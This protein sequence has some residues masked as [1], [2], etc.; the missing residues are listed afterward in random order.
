MRTANKTIARRPFPWPVVG[1]L[2]LAS[3]S[4]TGCSKPS[5]EATATSSSS[6]AAIASAPPVVA[7]PPGMAEI[8]GGTFAMG[9]S[10]GSANEKPVHDV[11]LS[12]YCLDITEVT[13]GAYAHCTTCAAEKASKT[14]NGLGSGKDDHPQNCVSWH[15]AKAY[16]ESVDKQLPTEAE[17]EFAARGGKKQLKWPWGNT[18][19]KADSA[20][21]NREKP[22]LGTCPVKSSPV[23]AFGLYDMAGNVW[24]WVGDWYD[25]SYPAGAGKDPLGPASG[26]SRAVRGGSW[27]NSTGGKAL[28]GTHRSGRDTEVPGDSQFAGFRCARARLPAGEP[29]ATAITSASASPNASAVAPPAASERP[30]GESACPSGMAKIPGG[31]FAMGSSDGHDNEKPVHDVELSP[32]CIDLT[33]VTVGAYARCPSCRA[34]DAAEGCNAAGKG[35]DNHPQNCVFREDAEAFCASM[36]KQLPTEAQW[37]YAARGGQKQSKWP[38]GDAPPT[39]AS[40]CWDRADPRVFTCPVKAHPASTFGLYDMAG[41]VYEWVADWYQEPY[42]QAAA[43]DPLG[44]SKGWY[45]VARGG[46]WQADVALA[47]RGTRRQRV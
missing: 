23:E 45:Y 7:C 25:A 38:W 18:K 16:C 26:W 29:T 9:S 14:C 30:V 36:G 43:K 28:R 1:S 13:V 35:K 27:A 44:P 24:E 8:P 17:W 19:P 15:D 37:E 32:Y 46:S 39:K 4:A 11:E 40:A 21:W 22:P 12:P 3:L 42:P 20:C 5:G 41:N 33:E 10:D 31:A 47:L 6:A 2:A 34:P